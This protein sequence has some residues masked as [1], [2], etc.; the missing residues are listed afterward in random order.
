MSAFN[1]DLM[2]RI[3]KIYTKHPYYGRLKI[4]KQ[5]Q[6]DGIKANHKRVGRLMAIMGI[7]AII[8][9]KNTSKSHPNHSVYPYLLNEL[10]IN[11]PNQVWGTDITYVRAGNKIWFYLVAILD[12]FS[13]INR[14][15]VG[16]RK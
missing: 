11:R 16:A 10:D 14:N 12:W 8:P 4:A 9:R 3:D 7:Q 2:N 1:V 5:L 6:R 13:R 15:L